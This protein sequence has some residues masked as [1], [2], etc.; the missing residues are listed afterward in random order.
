MTAVAVTLDASVVIAYL[1]ADERHHQEAVDLLE[2]WAPG[3]LCMSSLTLA[4][5]LVAYAR[6]DRMAEGRSMLADLGIE[7]LPMPEDAA[8]H[9]AGLRAATGLRLPDCCVLLAAEGGQTA[10]A[11][12]DAR[13]RAA[14]T[15]RGVA[16]V[17]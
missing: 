3:R 7:E 11:S 5:V 17:P 2:T 9:L 4:E 13:L 10:L 1:N 16:V 14:A 12:F 8:A 15:A 6:A